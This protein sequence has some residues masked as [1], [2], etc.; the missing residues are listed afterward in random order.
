MLLASPCKGSKEPPGAGLSRTHPAQ[1]PAG[2]ISMAKFLA[3]Q[4]L[5]SE[6]EG[7]PP[8]TGP[9]QGVTGFLLQDRC[10]LATLAHHLD[11]LTR[12]CSAL[13]LGKNRWRCHL[14]IHAATKGVLRLCE[15]GVQSRVSSVPKTVKKAIHAPKCTNTMSAKVSGACR[16]FCPREVLRSR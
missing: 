3:S 6:R 9:I 15:I 13:L 7:T 2:S 8:R 5:C 11:S 12:P 10:M 16:K 1:A 4:R 14:R